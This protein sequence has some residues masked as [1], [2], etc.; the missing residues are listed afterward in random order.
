VPH[1]HPQRVPRTEPFTKLFFGFEQMMVR[2]L[3]EG[4]VGHSTSC[5]CKGS[6]FRPKQSPLK[7]LT[8]IEEL[9]PFNG[10]LLRRATPSSQPR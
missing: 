9:L 7:W 3:D 6:G 8:F 5:H 2:D 10:R 4:K 1:H